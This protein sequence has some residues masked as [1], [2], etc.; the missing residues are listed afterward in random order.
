MGLGSVALYNWKEQ[1]IVWLSSVYATCFSQAFERGIIFPFDRWTNL[2]LEMLSNLFK[3]IPLAYLPVSHIFT[4]L[5]LKNTLGKE[6]ISLKLKICIF[7]RLIL[8]NFTGAKMM[9]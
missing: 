4:S 1:W 9:W 3:A 2:S 5:P 7:L 8:A 6:M